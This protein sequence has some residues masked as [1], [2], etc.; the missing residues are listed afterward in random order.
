MGN[1]LKNW[2]ASIVMLSACAAEPAAPTTTASTALTSDNGISLNGISLNGISVNGISLNGISVNGI[3]VNGISLNGISLNGISL[4]GISL[5]GISLNGISLNGISLNGTDFIGA[6]LSAVL[7]SGDSL[8]LR[9]DDIAP[10]AGDN[11]DVLAY[12]VSAA[13]DD[14]W[15]SLCGYEP[16]GSVRRALAVPGT[17]DV[18]TGAWTNTDGQFSFACRHASV[19]KC[20]E[21]GYKS[22]L[23]YEDHHHACVRMLR[24]D[25]CGDGT[26]HTITG[27]PINLYDNAGVQADTESW[28]VDAEWGPSGAL[29]VNHHRGGSQPSCYAAKY[30]ATCGSFANGALLVDEYNGL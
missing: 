16:D 12:A 15:T 29:C 23:G 3:S 19:A 17:W 4:N 8:A 22:W 20:V 9:L 7:S 26:P 10:L 25:Y 1:L 6:Q 2:A 14:G 28:P 18:G 21:L 11:A 13:T 5:N 27:T 30:S 24:A